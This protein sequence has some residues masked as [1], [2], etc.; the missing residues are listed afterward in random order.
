MSYS[1]STGSKP[2]S[3]YFTLILLIRRKAG[4]A[5]IT[6]W[7]TNIQIGMVG[8]C[9]QSG[10]ERGSTR[11][12]GFCHPPGHI[13]V[14]WCIICCKTLMKTLFVYFYNTC[15]SPSKSG[16]NRQL[17]AHPRAVLCK[18][19][20]RTL[21]F[22]DLMLRIPNLWGF[23]ILSGREIS[24]SGGASH[25]SQLEFLFPPLVNFLMNPVSWVYSH[26][27]SQMCVSP[28]WLWQCQN[29][30]PAIS[31]GVLL[32]HLTF[33]QKLWHRSVL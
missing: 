23:V 15:E 8:M 33:H 32:H 6:L 27:K 26:T 7:G 16:H 21:D 3:T 10:K 28:L 1:E 31:P 30:N 17:R 14:F 5:H 29:T 12:T 24:Y 11:G 13:R 22:A 25:A 20:K 18:I 4:N 19:C 9:S 2:P